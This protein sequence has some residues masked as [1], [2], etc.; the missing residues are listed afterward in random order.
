MIL[1]DTS[2]L[3]RVLSHRIL[4]FTEAHSREAARLYNA[5]GRG[6]SMRINA[7]VAA[8]AV[9]SNAEHATENTDDFT[10]FAPLG[11]RLVRTR[12]SALIDSP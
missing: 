11:L 2:Y 12:S 8:A 5:T 3:I 9:V 10:P 4:P 7:M 1:L 6:R